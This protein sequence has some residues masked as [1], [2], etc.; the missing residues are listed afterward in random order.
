MTS[1]SSPAAS[2]M[3]GD[4]STPLICAPC[5]ICLEDGP[6]EAGQPLIRACSCRGETSA[7]YHLSCIISYAK[8]KTK[9]A[10]EKYEAGDD[11]W[12]LFGDH[13][14]ECANCK[15][16]YEDSL[17][18][19]LAK[20]MVA[21]VASLVSDPDT[22]YLHHEAQKDM[23]TR[24]SDIAEQARTVQQEITLLLSLWEVRKGDIL[25]RWEGRENVDERDQTICHLKEQDSLLSTLATTQLSQD[26]Q[27]R[28]LET[29]EQLLVTRKN[30]K[31]LIDDKNMDD[32]SNGDGDDDE[33]D[34]DIDSDIEVVAREIRDM[35]VALGLIERSD[36]YS[37]HLRDEVE[38]LLRE[39]N[40]LLASKYKSYL[41]NELLWHKDPPEYE[42]AIGLL[43]E[44]SEGLERILGPSHKDAAEVN[45]DLAEA[46]EACKKHLASNDSSKDDNAGRKRKR[47]DQE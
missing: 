43:E 25:R 27:E 18:I 45:G 19:K 31:S 40:L 9:E 38:K 22:H 30:L 24:L 6:D 2:A 11:D 36:E 39:N 15:Q 13:W 35:K 28:A 34:C 7:G 46:K 3:V 20:E 41:A 17:G 44:A 42:E 21:Y 4:E 12:D 26:K 47:D 29:L 16:E 33:D 5:Y 8:A 32:D 1:V 14:L 10:V 37:A 23:L